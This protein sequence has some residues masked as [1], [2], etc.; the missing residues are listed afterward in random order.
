MKKWYAEDWTFTIEVLQVGKENKAE[1]CRLG[2][3]SRGYLYV[4]V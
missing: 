2:L 3:E 1:E 4:W